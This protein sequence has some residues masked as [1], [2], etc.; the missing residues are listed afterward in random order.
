[1]T[2]YYSTDNTTW[3]EIS[4]LCD[5]ANTAE[6][7]GVSISSDSTRECYFVDGLDMII[8]TTHF[9]VFGTLTPPVTT[10][11]SGGGSSGD[12]FCTFNIY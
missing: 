9:T 7:N 4:T 11:S 12:D 3:N 2:P 10:S 6:V 1:M 8:W 5:A